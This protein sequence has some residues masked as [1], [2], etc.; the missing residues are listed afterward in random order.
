MHLC[1]WRVNVFL[2]VDLQSIQQTNDSTYMKQ[3]RLL[4]VCLGNICRSPAAEEIMR[5][6]ILKNP[7]L[8]DRFEVDSAGIGPWHEGQLPDSR[9]RYHG[10]LHGYDFH[11][12]ARQIKANDFD[13][14][15]LVFGM[16]SGNM[17][18]LKGLARG[19]QAL[20]KIRCLADYMTQHPDYKVI[21]DP[22]YGDDEDFELAIAL[23]EDACSG[24]ANAL[25]LQMK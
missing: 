13:R 8:M 17:S 25:K 10:K 6:I 22:Y 21:P 18:D 15:D 12:I 2:T 11:H 23:I 19:T 1:D 20:S 14:F 9:M 5:Q 4:F 24:L 7:Q 3:Q 16:D